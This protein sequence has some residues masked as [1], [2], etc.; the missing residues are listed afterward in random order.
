VFGR[1]ASTY[2]LGL[3]P[4]P[5]PF[6]PQRRLE[7]FALYAVA[8]SLYSW[9]VTFSIF[10]FIWNVFKPYR[11]EVIGQAM[12]WMAIWGLVDSS[13]AGDDWVFQGAR[14]ARRREAPQRFDHGGDGAAVLAAIALVPL[15]QRV[16]CA[17][18]VRPR[19]EETVYVTVPGT[20]DAIAVKSGDRV[21]KG[22]KLLQLSSVDL[23]L[24]IA[25]LTGQ[26]GR[27]RARLDSLIR[28]RFADP[29]AAREVGTVE[30]ALKSVEEQ[31][32]KKR[33]DRSELVIVAPRDGVVLPPASVPPRPDPNGKLPMWA[34]SPLTSR[35]SAH[36]RPGHGR[37]HGG[38]AGGARGGDGGGSVGGGV[39]EARPAGRSE[40][41]RLHLAD[42]LGPGG[43]HRPVAHRGGLGA[44]EHRSRGRRAHGDRRS[45]PRGADFDELEVMMNLPE[46]DPLL[47]TITPGMRGT[48]RIQVGQ[49]TV[50]QWLLRLLWQTFN[51][52]M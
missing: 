18:E 2:C 11:L 28:E 41:R 51:F 17:A 34:G 13:A 27:C 16:W 32:V 52:R 25:D 12:G 46:G 10:L 21:T 45:G 49:R 50:G 22:Q 24:M 47:A 14:E 4:P 9:M 44:V 35:I 42:V 43:R 20:V 37:L 29:A 48:A 36:V 3:K 5:D 39:R 1:L 31:L 8:S 15:P 30:E 23:D 38:G 40:D 6:L 26:A 33:R 7:L 19:G